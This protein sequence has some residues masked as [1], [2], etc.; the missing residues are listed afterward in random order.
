MMLER[1]GRAPEAAEAY[2][3]AAALARTDAEV[4]FLSRRRTQLHVD[5]PGRPTG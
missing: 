2:E 5:L 3:R 4:S 1:L